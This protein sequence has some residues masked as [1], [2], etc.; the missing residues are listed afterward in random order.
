M[1]EK[2]N[3]FV[4]I[5]FALIGLLT[6]ILCY[7]ISLPLLGF[8]IQLLEKIPVLGNIITMVFVPNGDTTEIF[9]G[10]ASSISRK[11]SSHRGRAL[12]R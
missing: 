1:K 6:F 11:T 2:P 12:W 8:I 9:L 7:Y 4:S 3:Y 5:L 10:I